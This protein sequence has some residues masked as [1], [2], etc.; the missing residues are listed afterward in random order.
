MLP[1]L[2]EFLSE[3]AVIILLPQL[4]AASIHMHAEAI[5]Y[6]TLAGL[7]PIGCLTCSTSFIMT[8]I[9]S[10]Y[11]YIYNKIQYIYAYII[12]NACYRIGVLAINTEVA[13]N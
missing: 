2:W 7:I 10:Q 3:E 12:L 5:S 9:H 8:N 11:V 4:H 1:F 13:W 6:I